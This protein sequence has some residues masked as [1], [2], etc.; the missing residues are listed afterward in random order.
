[1]NRNK[2]TNVTLGDTEPKRL[3]GVD[4]LPKKMGFS[5]GLSQLLLVV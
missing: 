1:M 3:L 4:C 5:V 2:K